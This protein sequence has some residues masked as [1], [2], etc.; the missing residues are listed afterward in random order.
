VIALAH[1]H[2][3]PVFTAVL[4]ALV[5]VTHGDYGISWDEH[6]QSEYGERALRYYFSGG[7]DK[8]CLQFGNLKFYGPVF[9]MAA[10]L[11]YSETG[12]DKYRVRHFLSALMGILALAGVA[13][14]GGMTG[15][16]VMGFTATLCLVTTPLFY[17]H[18]Y[19]NSKD[20]PFAAFFVWSM[21]YT[22]RL[23]GSGGGASGGA[24]WKNA[25]AAGLAMG[26]TAAI[27]PTGVVLLLGM[28]GTAVGYRILVI[29]LA[30]DEKRPLI[31]ILAMALI[32]VLLAAGVMI[33]LWPL[34]HGGLNDIV[35]GVREGMRFS[36]SY[37]T[38]FAGHVVLSD[39]LPSNYILQ[40]FVI[41]T[42]LVALL[43][44]VTG[45]FVGA[46]EVNRKPD[47]NRSFMIFLLFPWFFAP[48]LFF[49]IFSANIYDKLRHFLFIMPAASLFAGL[50]VERLVYLFSGRRA[51]AVTV[52]LVAL[53]SLPI[54]DMAR[55]HPFQYTYFNSLVGGVAGASGRY[56]TEYWATSYKEAIEH[57]NTA[58]AGKNIRV[59]L[60]ANDFNKMC[61]TLYARPGVEVDTTEEIYGRPVLPWKIAS[62]DLPEQY[63]YYVA[64][65]R[66]G[67]SHAFPKAPVEH[68]VG[69][70]GAMFTV[71]K[72][73]E[74]QTFLTTPPDPVPGE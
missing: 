59:L 12:M 29:L 72:G 40:Y 4:L 10:A 36:T 3:L 67:M 19:I 32:Q 24:T 26:M 65:Y 44:M 5:V 33:I 69:R 8:S 56:E 45:L 2:W 41:T 30:A 14:F 35:T 28:L 20:V 50:A 27:R 70:I 53:L 21:V 46:L 60:A 22:A 73:R 71:I 52:A 47:S 9:E 13:V 43:L 68:M 55:L 7:E 38:L 37:P 57:I 25:V 18:W 42:P 63:D 49:V 51:T 61:A 48:I 31:R 39:R 62:G 16:R 74:R 58:S 66:F 23:L 34:A 15:S 6:V 54:V 17:G 11:V 1:R 64:S